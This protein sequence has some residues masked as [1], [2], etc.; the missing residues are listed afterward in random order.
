MINCFFSLRTYS[1][2]KLLPSQLYK[3]YS[4]FPSTA[5]LTQNTQTGENVKV[6]C[7]LLPDTRKIALSD[8]SETLSVCPADNSSRILR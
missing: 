6:F 3:I 5:D 4:S 7:P 2:M 8:D 1:T